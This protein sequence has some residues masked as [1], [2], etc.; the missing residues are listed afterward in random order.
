MGQL[1]GRD[2][3]LELLR[4]L[5]HGA[6]RGQGGALV[7]RGEAG[8]GKSCLLRAA[9]QHAVQHGFDV[10]TMVGT[11]AETALPFA[12]LHQLVLPV[13]DQVQNL[14]ARLQRAVR[15]AFGEDDAATDVFTLGLAVLELLEERAASSPVLLLVEDAHWLDP[16]TLEVIGFVCRRLRDQPIV[17]LAAV[18]AQ[19]QGV[20]NTAELPQLLLRGLDEQASRQL[21]FQVAP[22]LRA[23]ERDQV[24]AAA[25]GNPLG[26]VELPGCLDATGEVLVETLTLNER[27]TNAFT[28]RLALLPA[29]TRSLLVVLAADLKLPLASVVA[30][31][32]RAAE[33]PLAHRDGPVRAPSTTG[34]TPAAAPA[35]S[36]HVVSDG[37]GHSAGGG[38]GGGAGGSAGNGSSAQVTSALAEAVDAGLLLTEGHRIRFRHPL[39]RWAVYSSMSMVERVRVHSAVADLLI[40]DPDRR[41][42]HRAAATLGPDA[43]VCAELEAAADRAGQRGALGASV[44]A[45]E[46]AAVLSTDAP[47]RTALLLRAAEIASQLNDR[48]RAAALVARADWHSADLAGQAR[49]TLVQDII[50][51]GDLRDPGRVDTLVQLACLLVDAGQHDLAVAVCWRAASRCWWG[52]VPEDSGGQVVAAFRRMNLGADDPRTLAIEAYAQSETLGATVLQRLAHLL[53]D[54]SDVDGMRFLGRAALVLGD[55]VTASS[56]MGTA[57]AGYRVQ[58]R[59]A[60]LARTLSSVS[61]IRLWLGGWPTLRADAEEAF[62]LAGESADA[63]WALAARATQALHEAMRGDSVAATA[64]AEQVLA[65]P[66]A[67]G[68]HF[69]AEAAQHARGLAAAFEGRHEEAFEL[70]LGCFDPTSAT[71][72]PDMSGWALPDLA[73]AAVRSRRVETARSILVRYDARSRKLPS[74]ALVASVAY[75]RAVLCPEAE[76]EAAF[77]EAFSLDLTAWPVHRARLHLAYGTWLRRRRRIL[78]CRGPLREARDA[79]DA[80]GAGWARLAREELR[81]SGEDSLNPATPGRERLTSQELQVALLAADGLSNREIG[82]RLFLS[83][84]TVGSHLYR[85]YSKLGINGR[86]HLRAAL[87]QLQHEDPHRP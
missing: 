6:S 7:V 65:D 24:L 34:P 15:S 49:L 84:R 77:E 45:L 4:E 72:H 3:E 12:G 81:A 5:L 27:L 1:H 2:R 28:D 68:V 37:T 87:D 11:E 8:I 40:D 39:V 80:L 33:D 20:L 38:A 35:G 71:F 83:H 79:L 48:T 44:S 58:G 16:E 9:H 73:D 29:A 10:L 17:V 63:F 76:R 64:H 43:T 60:L 23:D 14:T 54:R 67:A 26:L 30:V 86:A 70:L 75:A 61:F 62:S 51:P 22:T 47:R 55:F 53:P 56:Y 42:W 74:P 25:E 32:R 31:A 59:A 36:G 19:H 66:H 46:R 57:A 52:A 41:V 18:R 21:L 50:E 82:Q 78:E 85:T 13:L 69:V